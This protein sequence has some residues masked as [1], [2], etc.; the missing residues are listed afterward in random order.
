MASRF[1]VGGTG[2]WDASDTTHWAATSNGAGGAS[3]PGSGD[4]VTLDGSSGGGTVT[5]NTTITVQSITCG[6][7]TGTLDFSANN[8]NCTVG[9]FNLSGSG[10]RTLNLGDG[11]FTLTN[12]ATAASWD[13]STATNLTL[14]A[15]GSTIILSDSA[16]AGFSRSFQGGGKTYN[17]VTFGALTGAGSF[18]TVLQANTI[19]TLNVTFPN[20]LNFPGGA[21]TTITNAFNWSGS[22]SVQSLLNSNS[23]S[24]NATISVAAGS[25]TISWAGLARL[26]FSGGATFTATSSFDFQ[27]N[28][29]ITI[30]PPASGRVVKINDISLVAA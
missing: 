27:G 21:T 14:N 3:V 26:T 12:A 18:Q 30:T 9:T 25:P 16:V 24:S 10:T 15:N 29:G 20:R 5:V 7:F 22:S 6:A 28:S 2:T 19:G 17:I 13:A 4:T 11:T 23:S 8:N 1:W